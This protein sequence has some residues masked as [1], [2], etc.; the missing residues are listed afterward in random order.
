MGEPIYPLLGPLPPADSAPRRQQPNSDADCAME[1][2]A[3]QAC[4]LPAHTLAFRS[5]YST[6]SFLLP[7]HLTRR[8]GTI[9]SCIITIS[10]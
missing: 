7:R 3:L 5:A 1:Y 4:W 10:S 9:G 8:V 2:L 6:V